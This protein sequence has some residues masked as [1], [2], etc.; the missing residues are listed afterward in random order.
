MSKEIKEIFA[1]L[2]KELRL[3][4]VLYSERYAEKRNNSDYSVMVNFAHE[5]ITTELIF[6]EKKLKKLKEKYLPNLT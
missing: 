6:I 5:L 4:Q 3:H 1:A 2:E